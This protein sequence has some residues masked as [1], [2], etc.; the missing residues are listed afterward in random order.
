MSALWPTGSTKAPK[1][2]DR[3]GPRPNGPAGAQPF[4]YGVDIP[5]PLGAL[6]FAAVDGTIVHAGPNG[7]LGDTVVID[8]PSGQYLYGHLARGSYPADETPVRRGDVIG[9]IGMT[10]LTTGPHTCFRTF[11]GSWLSNR[12][13]RDPEKF[14]AALNLASLPT[15]PIIPEEETMLRFITENDSTPWF[16]TDGMTKRPLAAGEDRLLVD[17]GLARYEEGA[18]PVKLLGKLIER[19]PTR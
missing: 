9:R 16:V 17:L 12:N 3:F 8:S 14:M 10:G 19:I 15:T 18:K 11:E 1:L 13:A 4:H 7:T 2:N 6:V 5:M